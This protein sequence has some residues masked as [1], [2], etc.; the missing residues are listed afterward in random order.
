M[1]RE[2][3]AEQRRRKKVLKKYIEEDVNL[4]IDTLLEN[5]QVP[6]GI[7]LKS[8]CFVREDDQEHERGL[9]VC[10]LSDGDIAVDFVD[11][12]PVSPCSSF[13]RTMR[14]RNGLG[15]SR[16]EDMNKVFQL[17]MYAVIRRQ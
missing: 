2:L 10:F 12:R 8:Q 4:V 15:G 3:T 17:L 7:T 6:Q 1:K 16:N 9:Q 11:E 5:Y 14:F 13:G